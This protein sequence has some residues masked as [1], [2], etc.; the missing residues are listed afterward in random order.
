MPDWGGYHG[1]G[2]H[3]R[4]E[5]AICLNSFNNIDVNNIGRLIAGK[6]AKDDSLL[7]GEIMHEMLHSCGDKCEYIPYCFGAGFMSQD[8][9][10]TKTDWI[11]RRFYF[12]LEE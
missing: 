9:D 6:P 12:E 5:F 2:V 7:G 11:K 8:W 3:K 1:S 10:L 4:C